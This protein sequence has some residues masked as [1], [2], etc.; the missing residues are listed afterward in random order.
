MT[1][2][3]NKEIGFYSGSDTLESLERSQH[4]FERPTGIIGIYSHPLTQVRFVV[5]PIVSWYLSLFNRC[6]CSVSS[7]SCAQV[8]FLGS[9]SA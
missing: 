9:T 5:C 8:R 1:E 2:M 6:V 7:V 3:M 4:I